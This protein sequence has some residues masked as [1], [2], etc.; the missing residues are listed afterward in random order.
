MKWPVPCNGTTVRSSAGSIATTSLEFCR[1]DRLKTKPVGSP[2]SRIPT[3]NT[4]LSWHRTFESACFRTRLWSL[5]FGALTAFRAVARF[6]N[7]SALPT[8]MSTAREVGRLLPARKRSYPAESLYTC[9]P[10]T[11]VLREERYFARKIR[12]RG[13][14][15]EKS[16]VRFFVGISD[17][18]SRPRSGTLRSTAGKGSS[19]ALYSQPGS[20]LDG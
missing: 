16:L 11:A 4:L 18:C 15:A 7:S 2:R 3:S 1:L 10:E 14:D 8:Y 20:G 13:H 17:G 19:P 6:T 9:N 12:F 5:A